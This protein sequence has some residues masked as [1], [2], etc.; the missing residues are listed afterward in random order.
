MIINFIIDLILIVYNEVVTYGG[1]VHDHEHQNLLV[2]PEATS[3]ISKK[4]VAVLQDCALL[5]PRDVTLA[6]HVSTACMSLK[7]DILRA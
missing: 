1:G 3:I 5:L 4:A 2:K 6:F 7:Y